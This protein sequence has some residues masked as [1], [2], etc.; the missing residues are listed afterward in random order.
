V[1]AI[2]ELVG[3]SNK[4]MTCASLSRIISSLPTRSWPT[5]YRSFFQSCCV[6]NS[7]TSVSVLVPNV[8]RIDL[9]GL[10][11][12]SLP[13]VFGFSMSSYRLYWFAFKVPGFLFKRGFRVG[14]DAAMIPTLI[15]MLVASVSYCVS[16]TDGVSK[17]LFTSPRSPCYEC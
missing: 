1:V 12:L 14:I 17:E 11:L 10:D 5:L 15:C 7:K 9:Q 13:M 16:L 3:T 4:F 6:A 8:L 2:V